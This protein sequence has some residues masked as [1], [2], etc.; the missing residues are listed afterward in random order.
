MAKSVLLFILL[1]FV[2]TW[3]IARP[4]MFIIP[5]TYDY[6]AGASLL[7][8]DRASG[9]PFFSSTD[10]YCLYTTGSVTAACRNSTINSI[11]VIRAHLITTLP[12]S[13]WAY[14]RTTNGV[15]YNP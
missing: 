9:A 1:L 10:S 8:Y 2:I 13:E 3:L 14:L 12:Y 6:P 5:P 7:Y 11:Q 4:A 15:M